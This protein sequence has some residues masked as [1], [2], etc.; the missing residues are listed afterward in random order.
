MV[1]IGRVDFTK[2][3]NQAKI[4]TL[5]NDRK[6]DLVMSD[7]APNATGLKALDIPAII[8]LAES[9]FKFSIQILK[10]KTGCFLTK[11]WSG[12]GID[13]F[14]QNQIEPFFEDVR[15]VRPPSTKSDS[16][17]LFLLA[18]NFKGINN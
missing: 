9:S 1:T 6:A 5:L 17:E 13:D 4:I 18:R 10:P 12:K 16:T 7:M 14:K 2:P 3:L 15:W 8:K 11:L